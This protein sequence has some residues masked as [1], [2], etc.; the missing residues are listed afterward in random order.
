[1]EK[2]ACIVDFSGI[3]D[4]NEDL[5]SFD[6]RSKVICLIRDS[7]TREAPLCA[8]DVSDQSVYKQPQ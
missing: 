2:P 7:F 8:L 4:C 6:V 3:S 5:N 1:M